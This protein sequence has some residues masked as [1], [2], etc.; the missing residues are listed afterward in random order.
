MTILRNILAE[1]IGLLVDD[2][3]FALL[4][5]VWVGLFALPVVRTHMPLTGPALF[6]GL[7]VITLAFVARKA[8]K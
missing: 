8:K 5:L 2:W 6:L 1:L 3:A 4:I 7:A